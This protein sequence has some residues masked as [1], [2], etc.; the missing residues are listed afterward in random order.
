MKEASNTYVETSGTIPEFIEQ[1]T[2]IDENRVFFGS[3]IPYYRFPTQKAIVDASNISNKARRKIYSENF[4][5]LFK[6]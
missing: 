2:D 1:T 4:D 5:R 6:P 3:D